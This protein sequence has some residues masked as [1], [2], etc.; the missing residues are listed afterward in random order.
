LPALKP[1]VDISK[2]LTDAPESM[3]KLEWK[4]IKAGRGA[5]RPGM[6]QA[7]KGNYRAEVWPNYG[8]STWRANLYLNNKLVEDFMATS[9]E[10]GKKLL[11]EKLKQ[12]KLWDEM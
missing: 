7:I 3:V 6:F 12:I 10:K 5:K 4:R 2:T 11:R 9:A 1:R 8:L